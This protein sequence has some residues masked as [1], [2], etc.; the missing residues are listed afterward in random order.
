MSFRLMRKPISDAFTAHADGVV[1]V[2][3]S[4][5]FCRNYRT[6][7]S[8]MLRVV[9]AAEY[10]TNETLIDIAPPYDELNVGS[11]LI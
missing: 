7:S 1:G 5:T 9:G 6:P 3:R 10:F 8:T 2:I 11:P 4:R